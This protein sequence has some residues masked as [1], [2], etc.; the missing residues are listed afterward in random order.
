MSPSLVSAEP[1][2]L[3]SPPAPSGRAGPDQAQMDPHGT[4]GSASWAL[5]GPV[6]LPQQ[7]TTDPILY[8]GLFS[9]HPSHP[10]WVLF[11][12]VHLY[13]ARVSFSLG[14]GT[15]MLRWHLSSP[16]KR[17]AWRSF[18]IQVINRLMSSLSI[19]LHF[20]ECT[21]CSASA[22]G[23][24]ARLMKL[25]FKNQW[26]MKSPVSITRRLRWSKSFS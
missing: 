5:L 21:Q 2:V 24:E 17:Q 20:K 3:F 13:R 23:F 18:Y 4:G 15:N 11:L 22:R 16:S 10:P 25:I 9:A 1:S 14:L 12:R 26:Q 7:F 8:F 6:P 19:T